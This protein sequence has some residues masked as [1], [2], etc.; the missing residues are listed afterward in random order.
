MSEGSAELI[1]ETFRL[2]QTD[3]KEI[4]EKINAINLI[5]VEIKTNQEI[6]KKEIHE[7]KE[8]H[9]NCDGKKA[10]SILDEQKGEKKVK[11]SQE[12]KVGA[13]L[14]LLILF[15]SVIIGVLKYFEK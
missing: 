8:N 3:I 14:L 4:H 11:E 7:L 5:V 1:L 15:G 6:D 9:K 13:F 10:L 2:I 12:Y